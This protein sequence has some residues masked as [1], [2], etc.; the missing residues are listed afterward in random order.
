MQRIGLRCLLF[1][2]TEIG[3]GGGRLGELTRLFRWFL[4]VV[5]PDDWGMYLEGRQLQSNPLVD[6]R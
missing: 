4:K 3:I 6:A 5:K 1:L 2:K